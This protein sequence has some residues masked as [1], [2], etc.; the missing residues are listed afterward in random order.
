MN[1]FSNSENLIR[2]HYDVHHMSNPILLKWLFLPHTFTTYTWYIRWRPTAESLSIMSIGEGRWGN[3]PGCFCSVCW[4][5]PFPSSVGSASPV[6]HNP[7]GKIAKIWT[8]DVELQV[9]RTCVSECVG[10]YNS[11]VLFYIILF[12]SSTFFC[13]LLEK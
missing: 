6:R 13:F 2:S 12:I 1:L 4:I 5:I 10:H 7:K 11:I 8:S 3:S 9:R